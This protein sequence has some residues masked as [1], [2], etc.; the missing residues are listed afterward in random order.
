MPKYFF[1]NRIPNKNQSYSLAIFLHNSSKFLLV[2]L[3]LHL[4]LFN[5]PFVSLLLVL[6]YGRTPL[7]Y[8][9]YIWMIYHI[10]IPKNGRSFHIW[11]RHLGYS[12][13]HKH[14]EWTLLARCRT[15]KSWRR[16]FMSLFLKWWIR[17]HFFCFSFFFIINIIKKIKTHTI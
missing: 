11:S 8:T 9:I 12:T 13:Y 14:P 4:F 17:E 7:N 1:H 3:T 2:Y 15:F 16:A 5:L 10:I 6:V